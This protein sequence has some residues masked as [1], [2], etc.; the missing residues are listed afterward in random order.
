M[1]F[2]I[3]LL[4][5]VRLPILA[6]ES[7]DR[8]YW[9]DKYLSVSYPLHTITVTSPYGNRKDPFTGE[10]KLHGGLD[11]RAKNEDVMAMFDGVVKS[12][13]SDDRSGHY[14]VFDHG[15]YTISYCHLSKIYVREGDEVLAGDVVALSGNTGRSTAPH[16]HITIRKNG[17][18][19]NPYTVLVYIKKVREE[20]IKKLGGGA[21]KAVAAAKVDRKAFLARYATIAMSHQL[22]YGIP[23]SVTLAQLAYE[24]GW[25]TSRL[26]VMGNNMFGI[27]CS[28]EWLAAGKPYSLHSD[29]KPNEKFC[30]YATVQE[31]FEHHS[32]L[33]MGERYARCRAYSSLDYH[34]WLVNIKRCGYATNP[35]Y[36]QLCEKL[37][38]QYKL[39]EYDRLA[40]SKV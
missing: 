20:S 23:S 5:F 12:I 28:K 26:A 4:L 16:L 17:K 40:L 33:L 34:N 2:L 36:V 39:W 25:G 14:V 6:Q 38:K 7:G 31:S 1:H 11:L 32:Q 37:I 30:N 10:K 3:L 19:T 15:E 18:V 9:I 21:G 24:S 8:S 13:G 29:D 22:R 35:N 27:K